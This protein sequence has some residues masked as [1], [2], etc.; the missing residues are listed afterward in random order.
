MLH[1][2]DASS[3]FTGNTNDYIQVSTNS[4]EEGNYIWRKTNV[5][6]RVDASSHIS[7]KNNTN[8][9]IEPGVRFDFGTNS[10]LSV[11]TGCSLKAI[12]TSTEPIIFSGVDGAAGA[13]KGLEF[14][15]TQS[16]NNQLD[17]CVIEYAGS[18]TEDAAIY[19]WAEP[20]LSVTNCI[21][22]D[23]DG[24]AFVDGTGTHLG[25]DNPNFS[26]SGNTFEN[27]SG[28]VECI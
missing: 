26:Q 21:I 6:F 16:I 10:Q 12:G 23:V 24:C 28:G 17:N 3:D 22:R 20:K 15:F 4:V 25:F 8:V 27:V 5:P 2:P 1:M 13:W 9:T 14:S 18:D 19:M 11:N 7:I